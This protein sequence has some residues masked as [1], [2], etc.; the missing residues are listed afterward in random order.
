VSDY[1]SLLSPLALGAHRLRNRIVS[2]PHATG[3][4]AHGLLADDEVTYLVRKAEGGCG[5]VMAFGSA[6]VDPTTVASYGSVS[7]WDTRNDGA[8]R[9]VAAG[10][11]AHGG[12]S[13]AQMTHMGRRGDSLE[14]GI[15]LR[16][17]SD[18]PEGVHREVPVPLETAAIGMIVERFAA[19]AARLEGLG[20][21]GCEVTSFGGHLI[22][23]F[24]D[25]AV[26][27]RTDR[28]GGSLVNRARFGREVLEAVRAAVSERF[29]V[30]FR[31]AIDQHLHDGLGPAAMTAAALA[32]A[33]E[34]RADV[35][36]VS[37]GTGATP[38][39][40]GW[41]VPPDAVAE[42]AYNE[43][44]ATFRRAV[45][46]PVIV[47]GRNVEPAMAERAIEAGIDLIGMTRAIIADP[48]LAARLHAG[49]RRGRPCTGLNDGCIGRVY[50]GVGMACS[51][52][53]AIREPTL[54]RLEATAAPGTIVVVGAGVAG[55]EAARGAA[56]RGHRVIVLERRDWTGGRAR[57]APRREGRARWH[58]QVDWLVRSC[59]DAGVDLRLGGEADVATVLALAP[60]AV[61]M[62]TGSIARAEAM[63]PGPVPV[64]DADV[65]LEHGLPDGLTGRRAL[66]LD[67]D[68]ALYAA[69]AAEVLAGEGFAVEVA[70][71]HES[72][73]ARVDATQRP[74]AI[75]RFATLG[76]CERTRVKGVRSDADG[77]VL[78]HVYTER[79]ERVDGIDLVVVAGHRRADC[80]LAG[81]LRVA[82]PA[83][84]VHV[85]GDALAPRAL[86]DAV[87]EG[88]RIGASI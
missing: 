73:H 38:L 21:D 44:A 39:S 63:P 67:D 42:G 29:L 58:L 11:R 80:A 26:N 51:V 69:T 35:I 7:L 79:E 9:A 18:R 82:A 15:A 49:R 74:F 71:S 77:V 13:M 59:A 12:V 78:R 84:A 27:D 53:P 10:V 32:V 66:V 81:A 19:A 46:L 70:T 83:L 45:G 88:A 3:W 55:L 43:A 5:L 6:T 37:A 52:N 62:A 50:L 25:P 17:P 40:T 33:G 75:R 31:M 57:L 8:L 1:P 60:M 36:S 72:V 68:G 87:A 22:E 4:G 30:G 76:I 65:L 23:Q 20:W 54:D 14:S 24:L 86:L 56:L 61:V 41:F 47:A 64:L 28:Y 48:D 2:T 16:A 34:G 85:I